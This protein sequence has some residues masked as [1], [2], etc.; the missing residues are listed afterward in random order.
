ML[1][2][3]SH[4]QLLRFLS[5]IIILTLLMGLFVP[6]MT[7]AEEAGSYPEVESSAYA[8]TG[9]S[10][11]I[12]SVLIPAGEAEGPELNDHYGKT[13]TIEPGQVP[14]GLSTVEWESI[15]A[16]ITAYK[17]RFEQVNS[18][19]TA[20]NRVQGWDLSY[21]SNGIK[22]TPRE[23]DNW[24][25]GLKLTGY[26]YDDKDFQGLEDLG[27]LGIDKNTLTYQWDSNLSEWWINDPAGL[28][29][30]FTLLE[31]PKVSGIKTPWY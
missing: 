7:Y 29:Q 14:Q 31:R 5:Y 18:I 25:W 10:Q 19:A 2:R 26:G 30:G 24:N 6:Q 28:E 21:D 12:E 3:R 11:T 4:F 15:Q 16:A 20:V 17:F 23:D 27:G 13:Q 9:E 1:H 8:S 22:V